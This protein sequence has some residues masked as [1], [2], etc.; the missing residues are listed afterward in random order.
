MVR[1][2]DEHD[3]DPADVPQLIQKFIAR[4]ELLFVK[5]E[6][7]RLQHSF[8]AQ[9]INFLEKPSVVLVRKFAV[10]FA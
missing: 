6:V 10:L 2:T 1:P 8:T 9:I 7:L 3:P 4:E 5:G